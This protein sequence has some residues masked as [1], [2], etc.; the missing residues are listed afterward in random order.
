MD[1]NNSTSADEQKS[2]NGDG[3]AAASFAPHEGVYARLRPSPIHGVGVFAIR[4]IPKGTNIFPDDDEP[5]RWVPVDALAGLPDEIRGLYD[6]FSVIK[7]NGR[8]YGCPRS[9]NHLTVSWYLNESNDPNVV[10]DDDYDFRALRD[11]QAGEE[12]TVDYSTFSEY[13]P[14]PKA[15]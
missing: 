10:C 13:P 15:E 2:S 9:F 4:A 1:A 12:L 3:F 7:D 14:D 8:L 11:I 5:M 6:D